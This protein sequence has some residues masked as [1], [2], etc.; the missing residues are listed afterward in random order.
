MRHRGG[1]ATPTCA[2]HRARQPA[3]VYVRWQT[4]VWPSGGTPGQPVTVTSTSVRLCNAYRL[5]DQHQL[6]QC[7][8]WLAVVVAALWLAH[9][10]RV[11]ASKGTSRPDRVCLGRLSST[12]TDLPAPGR[13]GQNRSAHRLW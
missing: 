11:L 9:A 3:P 8:V 5:D 10:A 7:L 13:R 4:H 1:D 6:G 12:P 2:G